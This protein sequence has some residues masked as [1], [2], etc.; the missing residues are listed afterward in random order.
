MQKVQYAPW[1]NYNDNAICKQNDSKQKSYI[2]KLSYLF[3]GLLASVL[4]NYFDDG[5]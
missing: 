1:H 5:N 3:I 4:D 2:L